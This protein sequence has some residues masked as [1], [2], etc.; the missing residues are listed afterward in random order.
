MKKQTALLL[1]T[2]VLMS[3]VSMQPVSA[4][5]L[6]F[7]HK[8]HAVAAPVKKETPVAVV[9]EDAKKVEKDVVK[10]V[11]KVDTTVKT[12]VKKVETNVKK[13][14]KKI[15]TKKPCACEKKAVKPCPCKKPVAKAPV[16]K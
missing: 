11:K 3:A 13:E 7:E 4:F 12:D 8:K 5:S 2:L 16:K 9:K 15:E 14:V 10:D 1:S 6:K